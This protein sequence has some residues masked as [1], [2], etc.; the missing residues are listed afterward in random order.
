MFRAD[1]QLCGIVEP[2]WRLDAGSV[3]LNRA[4]ARRLQAPA[5]DGPICVVGGDV[6]KTR[7]DEHEPANNEKAK[8][9][10]ERD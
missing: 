9:H 6:E 4:H 1:Q 7:I 10:E 2:G 3:K 8:H 5:H